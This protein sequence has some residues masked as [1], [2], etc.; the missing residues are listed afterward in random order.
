MS[1]PFKSKHIVWKCTIDGPAAEFPLKFSSLISNGSH[2][3]LI[4]PDT[5]AKL[6]LPVLLLP[7]PENVD[8]VIS[9]SASKS[10]CP[11]QYVEFKVM[12]LDG[13]WTSHKTFAVIAPGL[14]M[15]L[16]LGLPFLEHNEIIC[17]HALHTCIHKKT[18]YNLLHP[19]LPSPPSSTQNSS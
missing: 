7:E 1:P 9:S 6:G 4:C 2:L 14:C 15:L 5:V 19:V 8:I 10:M 17:D 13:I 11:S 3:V 12:S 18:K 16:I